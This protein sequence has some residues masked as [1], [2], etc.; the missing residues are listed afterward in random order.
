[1]WNKI[2]KEA[3]LLYNNCAKKGIFITT[4]ESCT[5]GLIAS[6]IVSI[7]GSSNIFKSSFITYSNQ[8]KTKLLNIDS[9]IIKINGAVSEIVATKMAKNILDVLEADIS[10]A[11][12]G[13]AGP[14]GGSKNKPVGLV[15]IAIG[16]KNLTITEKFLFSGNRLDIRQKTTLE[17]LKLA[18][19]V[20][21]N[22]KF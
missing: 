13:I 17:A 5:G 6:S 20:I 19:S 3:E 2:N 10:I 18:N 22:T 12:T 14:G 8:M 9:E 1:M 4:A 16:N 7:S 21:I 15:W 11:V